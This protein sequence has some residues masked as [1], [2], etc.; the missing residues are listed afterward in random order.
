MP[1]PAAAAL[2]SHPALKNR[3]PAAVR[4]PTRS[5]GS[6]R[7]RLTAAY[8]ALLVVTSMAF[9][10]G[11]SRV[12]TRTC[13]ST[14]ACTGSGVRT[15]S[16][17]IRPQQRA[18]DDLALDLAGAVPDPLHPGVTPPALNRQLGHQAHAAENLYRR[19]GHPAEHL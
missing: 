8:S 10:F 9:A 2:R 1:S 5:L 14:R 4:M 19:I 15:I 18:G 6:L 17:L 7:S 16:P 13:P 3:S 12:M 11:R